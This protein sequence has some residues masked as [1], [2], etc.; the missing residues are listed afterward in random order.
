MLKIEELLAK[1]GDAFAADV[2]DAVKKD[3]RY[4]PLVADAADKVLKALGL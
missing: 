1:V 2:I 4:V 3:S